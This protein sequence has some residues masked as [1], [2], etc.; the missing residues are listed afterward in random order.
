[1]V[2]AS[3]VYYIMY[4]SSTAAEK[5]GKL[6]SISITKKYQFHIK[7]KEKETFLESNEP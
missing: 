7:H 5:S 4:T 1:M 6:Q 2:Y 3:L